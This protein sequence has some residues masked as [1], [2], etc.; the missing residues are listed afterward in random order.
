MKI[1]ESQGNTKLRASQL[2][3]IKNN[4]SS[5]PAMTNKE[6]ISLI[7]TALQPEIE[8]RLEARR[9]MDRI[10]MDTLLKLTHSPSSTNQV[11]ADKR[12]QPLGHKSNK[13][14]TNRDSNL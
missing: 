1:S 13:E 9:N 12:T 5:L 3:E 8:K 6:T 2:K 4:P 10:A 14:D 11:S 7:Q